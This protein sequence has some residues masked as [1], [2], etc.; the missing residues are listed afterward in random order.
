MAIKLHK[1]AVQQAYRLI[2]AGE[3]DGQWDLNPAT[4]AEP[5]YRLRHVGNG[6]AAHD[7]ERRGR[8]PVC[9]TFRLSPLYAPSPTVRAAWANPPS[10]DA[11]SRIN[12]APTTRQR[13]LCILG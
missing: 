10:T 1:E 13:M 9:R 7:H 4:L 2:K 5:G 12:I 6:L 3:I 11:N 8:Q